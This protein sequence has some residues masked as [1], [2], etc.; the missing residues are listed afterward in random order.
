MAAPPEPTETGCIDGDD[1]PCPECGEPIEEGGE[2]VEPFRV[3]RSCY[4]AYV[5]HAGR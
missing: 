5:D 4:D 1:R 2:R 3:C